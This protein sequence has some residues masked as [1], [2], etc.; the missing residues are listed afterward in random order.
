M[1]NFVS[2][3]FLICV[4]TSTTNP[5]L[6]EEDVKHTLANDGLQES[7][8]KI[9]NINTSLDRKDTEEEVIPN[10]GRS[11]S[12]T[13]DVE[14]NDA[15]VGKQ[16]KPLRSIFLGIYKNYKSTY[17]GNK[18]LTEYKQTL[19]ETMK[20][21]LQQQQEQEQQDPDDNQ[22]LEAE[23]QENAADDNDGI[24]TEYPEV[25]A[26]EEHLELTTILTPAKQELSPN[27]KRKNTQK[28]SKLPK[29]NDTKIEPSPQQKQQHQ[30]QQYNIG[31]ALNLSLD[32]DNSIVKVNLD[33]ESLKELVTG[34]WLNDNTEE[35]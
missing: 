32:I 33:G 20:N 31:P 1:N 30:H 4:L 7:P 25:D 24:V 29:E 17:L 19:R 2:G 13:L 11:I 10:E 21:K 18:T 5:S 26:D 16:S 22:S 23:I 12:D 8:E 15:G 6:S 9:L 27:R 28:N 35:G 34:R 3:L 14:D